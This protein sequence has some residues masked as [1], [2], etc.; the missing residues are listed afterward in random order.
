M[1]YNE[2]LMTVKDSIYATPKQ[3]VK[4]FVFDENVANVFDDMVERSVPGYQAIVEMIGTLSGQYA[5]PR[6]CCYD[7]GCSLGA[8]TLSMNRHIHSPDVKI[9]AVDN[10]PAMVARCRQNAERNAHHAAVDVVCADIKDVPVREASVVVLNFTL[11]FIDIH[12][13]ER[14]IRDIYDG[15]LPRG[16]LIIS[17]KIAFEDA[18]EQQMQ[19]K[20]HENF[21]RLNG[22]TDLEIAQKRTALEK[23]LVPETLNDHRQRLATCGFEKMHVW[24]QC[25][26]FASFIAIK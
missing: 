18:Q 1:L 5:K 22:Y 24:F 11:Q 12:R 17:E 10:S 3:E 15:M 6:S 13:R 7:L 8:V 26:N 9:I 4:N 16:L 14:L 25:F 2:G 21:K 20:L 19:I 23:V